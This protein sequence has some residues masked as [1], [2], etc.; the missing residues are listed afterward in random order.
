MKVVR[1]FYLKK[2]QK[3][4]DKYA[5]ILY[6]VVYKI[7]KGKVMVFDWIAGILGVIMLVVTLG[8]LF[9]VLKVFGFFALFSWIFGE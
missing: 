3:T 2:N 1:V 4:V 7:E 6:I 8:L 5:N 9:A